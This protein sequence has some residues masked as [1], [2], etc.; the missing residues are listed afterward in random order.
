MSFIPDPSTFTAAM[1]GTPAVPGHADAGHFRLAD[2][3][4]IKS[5]D[6]RGFRAV[7]ARGIGVGATIAV[8]LPGLG[9]KGAVIHGRDCDGFDARFTG[10]TDLRMAFI[11]K[12]AAGRESG[13]DI[14]ALYA[15][16]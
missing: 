10:A 2:L 14:V 4:Q 16:G 12:S 7:G 11:R 9:A 13:K 3:V 5:I 6:S 15:Q 1:E 8:V